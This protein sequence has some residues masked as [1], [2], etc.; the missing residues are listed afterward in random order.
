MAQVA[1]VGKDLEAFGGMLEL[2][3]LCPV[4]QG[5]DCQSCI[6]SS[7]PVWQFYVFPVGRAL[8]FGNSYVPR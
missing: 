8:I 1:Y 5:L 7:L 3:R 6:L 4:D 2:P